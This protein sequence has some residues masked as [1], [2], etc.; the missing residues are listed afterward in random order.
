MKSST[1]EP[2]LTRTFLELNSQ[3]PYPKKEGKNRRRLF[4]SSICVKREAVEYLGFVHRYL[5]IV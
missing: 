4:R 2:G 3:E 1:S 5:D